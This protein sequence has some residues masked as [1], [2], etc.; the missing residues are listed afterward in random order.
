MI[1]ISKAEFKRRVAENTEYFQRN[2]KKSL[3]ISRYHFF[4]VAAGEQAPLSLMDKMYDIMTSVAV[5]AL[6]LT[7]K[8]GADSMM[9]IDGEIT[10][11]E[12][13]FCTIASEKFRVGPLGGIY[14][15]TGD[16][17]MSIK[18]CITAKWNINSEAHLHTKK[19]TTVLVVYDKTTNEFVDARML[20]GEETLRLLHGTSQTGKKAR[21]RLLNWKSFDDNGIP[22]KLVV[23]CMTYN[24]LLELVYRNGIKHL[25]ELRDHHR[26][27]I[28]NEL[29]IIDQKLAELV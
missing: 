27:N 13:K 23:P 16:N 22:V 21:T 4:D 26:W 20:N 12:M 29:Q 24:G 10:P 3:D 7:N 25:Y 2:Y 15:P 1:M 5:G 11:V 6:P 14:M 8:S 19:R 17:V 28:T 18:N 9:M